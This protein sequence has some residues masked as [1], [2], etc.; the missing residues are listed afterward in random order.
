MNILSIVSVFGV[1][2]A[3]AAMVI[4]LSVFNGF[5]DLA[6][7]KLSQLDPDLLVKPSAG[8]VIRK[9]DSLAQKLSQEPGVVVVAPMVT[10][11]ALAVTPGVQSPV[12]MLGLAPDGIEASNLQGVM[13]D[14]IPAV[15]VVDNPGTALDGARVGVLSVG[16]AVTTG[17]RAGTNNVLNLYVPRRTGRINVANPMMAFVGDSLVVAGVYRVE[18]AEYDT[19]MVIVPLEMARALLQY[20]DG[21]ASA[22]QVYVDGDVK[23]G[24]VARRL[25]SK[26]GDGYIVLDRV[27]QQQQAFNMIAVEK[28]MTLLMLAFILVITSFNIISAI[29]ILRV[30]K[31]DNMG[32]L[33]A[34][35]ASGGMIKS[36]FAWQGRLITLA[37]GFIGLILGSALTL[38]QQYG[39][40]IKLHAG[41]TSLLSVESYPVRLAIGDIGIVAVIV[42]MVALVCARLSVIR[43]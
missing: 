19:D 31:Q 27:Q 30:E 8:K 38:L 13:I 5:N 28:W 43:S 11:Q 9:A 29:Y 22:I 23:A 34:M 3:T 4:V 2:I 1:A 40:V 37:G 39:H 10:E 36:I 15:G 12:T 25:R 16:A 24:D 21:E 41:D 14:G 17:L 33:R 35:G 7:S 42:L 6:A 18:Q 20:D 32:V 26:L